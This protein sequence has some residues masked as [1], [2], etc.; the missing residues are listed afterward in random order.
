VRPAK[1]IY[2]WLAVDFDAALNAALEEPV[3]ALAE[4]S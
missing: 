2:Y 1:A 4:A 3:A